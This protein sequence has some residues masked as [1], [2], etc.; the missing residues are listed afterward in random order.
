[1]HHQA[2]VDEMSSFN[3]ALLRSWRMHQ[4]HIDIARVPPSATPLHCRPRSLSLLSSFLLE[5]RHQHVEQSTVLR[6]SWLFPR[7]SDG[8]I[9]HAPSAPL[10]YRATKKQEKIF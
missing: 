6:S 8:W 5:S 10:R 4:H 9:G 3:V 7:M 1:V 2:A